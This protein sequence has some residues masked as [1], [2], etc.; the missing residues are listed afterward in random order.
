[1][2]LLISVL[3]CLSSPAQDCSYIKNE[4]DEF[5]GITTLCTSFEQVYFAKYGNAT[6]GRFREIRM[7]LASFTSE[8]LTAYSICISVKIIGSFQFGYDD[9]IVLLFSDNTRVNL[10]PSPGDDIRRSTASN[11]YQHMTLVLETD[12]QALKGLQDKTITGIRLYSGK[13]TYTA[14]LASE[15]NKNGPGAGFFKNYL[16]CILE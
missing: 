16:N 2:I 12:W 4:A 5:T 14:M 9:M 13:K 8:D 1:M 7:A 6:N 3:L 10:K 15:D 11:T